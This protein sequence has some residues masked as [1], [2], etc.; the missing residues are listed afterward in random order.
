M[1][2]RDLTRKR[3][4]DAIAL[5]KTED[6]GTGKRLD[7]IFAQDEIDEAADGD[8]CGEIDAKVTPVTPL[9]MTCDKS[10]STSLAY[11][12]NQI[13]ASSA[14]GI[15]IQ[16]SPRP[17][18]SIEY[19]VDA[20]GHPTES[21]SNGN[22]AAHHA[23][24]AGFC[25]GLELLEY[26]WHCIEGNL[27]NGR[28]ERYLS[29]I[30]HTNDNGDTPVMMACVAGHV[31]TLNY[32]LQRSYEIKPITD[33]HDMNANIRK[34]WLSMREIFD[35]RNNEQITALNLACGHGHPDIVRHLIRP[36]QI[37][38]NSN[39]KSFGVKIPCDDDTQSDKKDARSNHYCVEP[40][41]E[42]QYSDVEF[43]RMTVNNLAARLKLV[44]QQKDEDNK[45][46]CTQYKHA[47]EC[48][49]LLEKELERISAKTF[50]ELLLDG[51]LEKQRQITSNGGPKS[52]IK[53]KKKQKSKC[54]RSRKVV[55]SKD[56]FD[57]NVAPEYEPDGPKEVD[58]RRELD[59]HQSSINSPF[60][61]L[62]NGSIVSKRSDHALLRETQSVV[63]DDGNVAEPIKTT[64]EPL[65]NI[66]QQST[67]IS[68]AIADDEDVTTI[69]ESLCLDSPMLLLT[70][71]EMAML[72]PC[73][74]DA[75]R[76]V[77]NH[78]LNAAKAAQKIQA[79]M[80]NDL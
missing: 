62:A 40:L 5:A 63:L 67:S 55:T 28:L 15:D 37:N 7:D 10:C 59:S 21:S 69:M 4:C 48:L 58:L 49:A 50:S 51:Q 2:H 8:G 32:I 77:L 61:T 22:S 29:L 36:L 27:E 79:K 43:S 56:A 65:R 76:E 42:V 75:I 68:S 52:K 24:A 13:G 73:Q 47:E 72:S 74:L 35:M 31:S 20:W 41:V 70:P 1:K 34:R 64:K 18:K 30:S 44:K 6:S 9:I 53:K 45:E 66:L 12:R 46:F 11:L 14:H 33:P 78:Q 17:C 3:I 38:P 57:A 71:H 26:M 23:S 39:E 80:R 60:V 54:N 19:L 25:E 16:Q